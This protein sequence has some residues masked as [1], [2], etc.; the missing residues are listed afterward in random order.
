MSHQAKNDYIWRMGLRPGKLLKPAMKSYSHLC[1]ALLLLL[2]SACGGETTTPESYDQADTLTTDSPADLPA[3]HDCPISGEV[4]E[5]NQFWA[6]QLQR[7]ITIS[8]DSTT[9]DPEL[10]P[11]HRILTVYNTETCDSIDRRV[12]PINR[13]ADFPYFIADILY[14][15]SSNLV[16]IRGFSELLIYDLEKG[17]LR[18]PFAPGFLRQRALTD[19]QSGMIQHLEVWEN[20]LIGYAQDKG[21]FVFSLSEEGELSPVLPFAEYQAEDGV[22]RSLFLLPSAEGQMQAMIP[23]YDFNEGT[24]D[25]NLQFVQPTSL[26][27]NVPESARNNRFLVLRAAN[28][29]S[30]AYGFDLRDRE[31]IELPAEVAGRNTQAILEWLRRN[32]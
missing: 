11:S 15:N 27:T 1:Y 21:T 4:L 22:Y 14:N 25:L 8:A 9:L 13:S 24:F 20:Y 10:G 29:N 23:H 6:R 5:G 26:S 2:L 32:G 18:E 19:A 17:E 30:T 3:T 28:D 16:G 12:L 7:L 31:R